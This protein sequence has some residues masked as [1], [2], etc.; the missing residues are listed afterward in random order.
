VSKQDTCKTLVETAIKIDTTIE[1]K[2]DIFNAGTVEAM[3]VRAAIWANNDIPEQLK[4]V[5]YGKF[6]RERQQQ[7]QK[8]IFDAKQ[9]IV[10]METMSRMWHGQ[11]QQAVAA[12]KEEYRSQFKDRDIN[13]KP[14]APKTIKP[15][16]VKVNS[17]SVSAKNAINTAAEKYGVPSALIRFIMQS[18][19]VEADAAGKIAAENM[20]PTVSPVSP[21]SPV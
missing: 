10:E 4:E 16:A 8:A 6:T 11:T 2:A 14:Q 1:L 9:A 15:R 13:Y 20:N 12:M 21:V 7:L 19:K 17:N 5:E 18:R 3:Q